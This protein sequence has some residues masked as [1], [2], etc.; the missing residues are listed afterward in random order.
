[1]L[2]IHERVMTHEPK[3][4]MGEDHSSEQV[5]CSEGYGRLGSW[6]VSNGLDRACSRILVEHKQVYS[7]A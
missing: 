3:E 2:G 4:K 6:M 1:M 7:N 5:A